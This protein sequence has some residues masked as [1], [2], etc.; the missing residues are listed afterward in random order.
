[1]S[2]ARGANH[3]APIERILG[4]HPPPFA[5]LHRPDTT[6]EHVDVVIGSVSTP[7]TLAGVELPD[8]A[9]VLVVVPFRQVAERGFAC[10]DDGSPLIAMRV[11]EHELVARTEVLARIPDEP[12]PL[13]GG[14]FEPDDDAYA[15]VVRRII[16]DEIAHGAGAN[17]VI[18]RSFDAEIP[19]FRPAAALTFFRRLCERE[20]GAY[21]TF[22]VHTGTRTFVGATPER[23]VSLRDGVAVMNPISGTYRYP[24]AGPTLTGVLKFLRDTK[25]ND[26]LRMVVDEELKMMA[27]V[28]AAGGRVVGPFLKEMARLA[29][30]EYLIE[31][32][33]TMDPREILRETM[34][35]PTVVGSPL[36][37][38]CRVIGRHE[39]DGRGYYSG[40]VALIGHD[41]AGDRCLDSAILIRTADIDD[42][43]HLRIGVGATLVR[44]SDPVAE[45]AETRA[46]AAG[47]LSALDGG[48]NLH[49]RPEVRAAL[50]RRN[51]DLAGFW[52]AGTE[53]VTVHPAL[54][55]RTV[56]VVDAE[57]TFTAMMA[58][59]LRA[60][61]L[62]VTVRRFDEDP[63]LTGHDLVLMGPGPGDP[64]DTGDPRIAYLHAAVESLLARRAPFVA[65]CLSHQVTSRRLG[66]PVRRCA[67]PNQGTRR[68]IDLFGERETVGFYN[69]FAAHSA[70][71]AFDHPDAGR[72]EVSRDPD[73]GE[74][75]ALR[76]RHFATMQ[77]HAES[78]LTEN[79]PRL[80][81]T[82]VRE[83]LTHASHHR[84]VG[85]EPLDTDD[86]LAS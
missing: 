18:R 21:W 24:P 69:S 84:L 49:A 48:A 11:T 4:P 33:S 86:R 58:H 38:A 32:R 71:D 62:R 82:A 6:G 45:V 75:H 29:H 9:D 68:D 83:V 27:R 65:V 46:K 23:H 60:V 14:H 13:T 30:T 78:V 16:D 73:T 53:S 7:D 51:A 37:S 70:A 31:G 25:E 43:G 35:A 22:I 17:F 39:P 5:I 81:A 52:L 63:T 2:G 36:E 26:E 47:L 15:E 67:A 1:V 41:Q 59:Q 74:V 85:P 79:G 54:V 57:D 77:F 28:C 56:L 55:G 64:T 44:H 40:V 42:R 19:G 20:A 50:N 3:P 80:F 34:F 72:V 76:G 8:G 10:V 66:L 12:I 61:G